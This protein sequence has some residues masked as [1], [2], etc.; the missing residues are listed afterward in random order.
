MT[1]TDKEKVNK[2]HEMF[3]DALAIWQ[4]KDPTD[5][6]EEEKLD[7]IYFSHILIIKALEILEDDILAEEEPYVPPYDKN[8]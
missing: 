2:I 6:S 4:K 7:E 3:F 5:Y 8:R 1:L